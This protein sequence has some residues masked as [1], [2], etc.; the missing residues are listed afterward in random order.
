MDNNKEIK[1]KKPNP[2]LLWIRNIAKFILAEYYFFSK[3]PEIEFRNLSA[4]AFIL[5]LNKRK[6]KERKNLFKKHSRIIKKIGD[7]WQEISSTHSFLSDSDKILRYLL[8]SGWTEDAAR[9]NLSWLINKTFATISLYQEGLEKTKET[10]R[11]DNSLQDMLINAL[12]EELEC[13][14][15]FIICFSRD[16]GIRVYL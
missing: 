16:K 6:G 7:K 10:L 9:S 3:E 4:T 11:K 2:I 8:G 5:E 14:D 1:F 15:L 13:D 12:L